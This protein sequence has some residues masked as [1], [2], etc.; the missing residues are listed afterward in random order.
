M[1]LTMSGV[2]EAEKGQVEDALRHFAAQRSGTLI[3]LT[4]S[5]NTEENERM[6]RD[7]RLLI[8]ES[9][10]G[11]VTVMYPDYF[12]M[13]DEASRDLSV[14]L[15][16]PVF[17]LHVHDGDLWMYSLYANG[18]EVDR[19]NPLPDYWEELSDKDIR[20]MV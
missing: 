5:E 19:F 11:H 9:E 20:E 4:A 2:A 14:S 3:P 16:K 18:Q 7:E 15:Q 8:T 6:L 17:A 1:F 12:L 10:Q 13:L